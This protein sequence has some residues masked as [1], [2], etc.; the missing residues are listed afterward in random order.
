M[1]YCGTS[2]A[3]YDDRSIRAHVHRSRELLSLSTL[4]SSLSTALALQHEA[5]QDKPA[6]ANSGGLGLQA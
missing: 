2:A 1:F 4:H 3:M 6:N 5:G